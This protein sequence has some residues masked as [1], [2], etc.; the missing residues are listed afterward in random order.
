LQYGP[1][2]YALGFQSAPLFCANESG[3]ADSIKIFHIRSLHGRMGRGS[4]GLPKVTPQP[5]LP[6]LSMP[7]RGW[8]ARRSGGL[9]P[10]SIPLDT[11]RRTGLGRYQ[12]TAEKMDSILVLNMKNGINLI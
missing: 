12:T 3:E 1:R 7:F 10:S 11:R 2:S 8:P 6:D 4:H 9:Q 5:A